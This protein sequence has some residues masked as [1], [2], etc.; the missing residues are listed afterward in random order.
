MEPK[1]KL[2]G[3]FYS[4]KSVAIIILSLLSISGLTMMSS[5]AGT[6]KKKVPDLMKSWPLNEEVPNDP[7]LSDESLCKAASDYAQKNDY[8]SPSCLY[9]T[10]EGKIK[11][12][13]GGK[14]TV[15][16]NPTKGV[17]LVMMLVNTGTKPIK[18]GE[19]LLNTGEVAI[20]EQDGN[21]E[22]PGI[23]LKPSQ[24]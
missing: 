16:N 2:K 20:L 14:L 1:A 5:C 11:A 6:T 4:I 15:K 13:P 12:R 22:L 9:V 23:I 24:E 8:N 19:K 7:N 10:T 17:G 21:I 18:I 3:V